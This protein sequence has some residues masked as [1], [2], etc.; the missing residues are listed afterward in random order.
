[1]RPHDFHSCCGLGATAL[2]L[3]LNLIADFLKDLRVFTYEFY[4]AIDL[5]LRKTLELSLEHLLQQKIFYHA[6]MIAKEIK[7]DN[8][9]PEKARSS[10][11]A[12][13]FVLPM[14]NVGRE[15]R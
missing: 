10:I 5:R 4:N 7:N 6:H 12:S 9:E 3:C 2:Y 13:S 14:K 1:M 8:K 11:T 15:G